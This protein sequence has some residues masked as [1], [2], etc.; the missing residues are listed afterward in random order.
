MNI[1]K[2]HHRPNYREEN[3]VYNIFENSIRRLK[4]SLKAKAFRRKT[5]PIFS[6]LSGNKNT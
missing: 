3:T 5:C 4:K 1:N 2:F 6:I